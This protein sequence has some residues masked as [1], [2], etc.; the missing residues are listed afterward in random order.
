MSSFRTLTMHEALSRQD[1]GSLNIQTLNEAMRVVA[2]KENTTLGAY[3]DFVDEEQ[4]SRA[5]HPLAGFSVA[6][7]ANIALSGWP[8]HCGSRLLRNYRSP[9][10]STA[11]SRLRAAGA[12][13]MGITAMDEFG[14]GSTCEHTTLGRVVNPWDHS[15]TAGGSSGGSAAAVAAGLAWYGLGSDTGGSVR[16]PAHFCGVAGLKP[17]W[18]RISGCG[19][20]AF[21]SSLDAIGILGRDVR[22]V[23]QVYQCVAGQD[24]YDATTVAT[25]VNPAPLNIARNLRG[26]KVGVPQEL[27]SMD[28][29]EDVRRDHVASIRR[30]VD[31][32]AIPVPVKL[33]A[34]LD[35]VPVYTVL[36]C[37]EAASNLHR[38][39]GSLYGHRQGGTSYQ[40]SLELTRTAGFGAEVK[41]RLL[42]GAHVL[43]SGY[44]D[45][46]YLRACAARESII[47]KF[48][49][50]FTKI[51]VL[52][53]PTA[54]TT[55]FPLN[56]FKDDPVR[57]HLTDVLTV[58]ASLAGL[59]ALTI[60]TGLD[61]RGLP[62][63]I[64][65]IGAAWSERSLLEWAAVL[66]KEW[67]FRSRQEAP[68][69]RLP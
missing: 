46:Y 22:D 49:E 18:G 5:S 33:G 7:K 42:L 27:S 35:A 41:R 48:E 31:L 30:M 57:M 66:E 63:S 17:T 32:G 14:M 56:S 51:D 1:D 13:F 15:C 24:P 65:L 36:N 11:V 28:L 9:F 43:S 34:V 54:P 58:P 16:L 67:N 39:D 59:P 12:R 6:I 38:F 55:A 68:W 4:S 62:M 40:D 37:A 47:K 10:D 44:Q 26:V 19:L 69:Q 60:P 2:R 53:M 8:T 20:V 23:H 52:A 50:I 61:Q 21:A 45:R 25:V 64:Q 29:A 3:T